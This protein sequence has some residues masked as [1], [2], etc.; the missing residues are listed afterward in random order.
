[1]SSFYK[2]NPGPLEAIINGHPYVRAAIMFGRAQFQAGVL[3]DP[4]D[5]KKIDPENLTQ[6]AKFRNE[7]WEYVE[8]ANAFAPKHSRIFKE[9]IVVSR[10]SKPFEYTAKGTARRQGTINMYDEEIKAA[11]AAVEDSSVQGVDPP[12]N[13]DKDGATEFVRNVVGKVLPYEV[14][15]DD[16]FFQIGA[17]RCVLRLPRGHCR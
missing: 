6:L 7:I 11:Y 8:R 16:D 10:P 4:I 14:G 1:M 3:I 5:E 12:A 15:D 17:D 9:M 13:W 2:T